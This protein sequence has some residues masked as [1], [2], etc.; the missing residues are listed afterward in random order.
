MTP[1]RSGPLE[2]SGLEPL[3][4]SQQRRDRLELSD[5]LREMSG[6]EQ[7]ADPLGGPA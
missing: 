3:D 5:L 4:F 7:T 1:R 2:G 6:I